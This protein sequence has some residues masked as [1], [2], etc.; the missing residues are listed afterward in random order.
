MGN[1]LSRLVTRTGDDGRTSLAD[2]SRTTKSSLR[3]HAIGEVDELNSWLGVVV[4]QD[5]T[6]DIKSMLMRIQH[7]L[8][9]IGGELSLP[10]HA[11]IDE[12]DVKRIEEWIEDYNGELPPLK[13]FILP[14]GGMPASFCHC[15][16]A[17]CRRA[18]RRLG[19]LFDTETDINPLTLVFVNRLSD[20]LFVTARTLARQKG[21]KEVYWQK[22][23]RR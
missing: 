18:E 14:G 12:T 5:V 7:A 4:D 23:L 13:E 17:V 19:E 22:D 21:G 2:G 3:I 15:A 16:R 11:V 10:G 9:D 6:Q 8:F 20:L 1:R